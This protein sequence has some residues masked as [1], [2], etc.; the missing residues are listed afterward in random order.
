VAVKVPKLRV[1]G[2]IPFT[3]SI[4]SDSEIRILRLF[5]DKLEEPFHVA[6]P[7][8]M[9]PSIS[10]GFQGVAKPTG[11]MNAT[12]TVGICTRQGANL[13]RKRELTDDKVKR[14]KRERTTK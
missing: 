10:K 7:C 6:L 5:L 8:N 4:F 3:R 12:W 13:P 2:P 1:E 14:R 11:N 9:H